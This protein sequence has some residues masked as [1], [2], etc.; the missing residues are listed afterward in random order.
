MNGKK[1]YLLTAATAIALVIVCGCE[2]QSGTKTMSSPVGK[3]GKIAVILDT[4]ICDDIDD[5][6]A[7]AMLL[8]SPEFD[9]KLITT[10]VGD[11]T[12]RTKVVAKILQTAGRTDIPI[13]TGVAIG[14]MKTGHRQD[15][16]VKDFDLSKYPGK[17]YQDGVQ[18]IIDTIM[19]S[20]EPITIISTGPLPNLAAA[21]EREPNIAKKARFVG[22]QGSVRSGYGEKSKPQKEY[23]VVSFIKASQTVFAADWDMTITPLD[24]CSRVVLQGDKYRKVLD[25]NSPIT[26]AII[27]NYYVWTKS[28]NMNEAQVG[29]RSSTLFDTVA[30]YLAMSHDLLE[31]ENLGIRVTDDGRTVIDGKAKKINCAT[32]WKNLNA[33]EDFL[34]ARLTTRVGA[35]DANDK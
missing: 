28:G 18:A 15:G 34:V 25:C 13:G 3:N 7:L 26:K 4:D 23:N 16:W 22:M 29:S 11:T 35:A 19:N 1:R 21:L 31:M 8:Q 5:T 6:W 27:E 24:T 2:Q 30:I 32:K 9:V 10:A 20:P 17:I 33:F 12:A 14:D